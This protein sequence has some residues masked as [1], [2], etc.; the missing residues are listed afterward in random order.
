DIYVDCPVTELPITVGRSVQYSVE[1]FIDRY[2]PRI[3]SYED[4][5][6]T[7]DIGFLFTSDREFTEA[8]TT[9]LTLAVREYTTREDWT[10]S[11]AGIIKSVPWPTATRGLGSIWTDW[12]DVV[13]Q[14]LGD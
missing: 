2:G 5:P 1:T 14:N 7:F 11:T 13:A 10:R 4:A 8:E 12:R 3:P 6:K 9:W